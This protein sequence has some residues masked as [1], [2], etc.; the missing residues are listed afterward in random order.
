M[1]RD[2]ESLGTNKPEKWLTES[3]R[4]FATEAHVIL[5]AAIARVHLREMKRVGISKVEVLGS[6]WDDTCPI[7]KR[8]DHLTYEI[9]CAPELPHEDCSC[10]SGC[11]CL[12]VEVQ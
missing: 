6:G 1:R 7:C 9:A 10:K 12:L 5:S 3:E 2:D 4:K 8:D 11:R